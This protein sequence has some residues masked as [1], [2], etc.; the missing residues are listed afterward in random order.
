[1]ADEL[2]VRELEAEDL[3]A[4]LALYAHLH[5]GDD[6]LPERVEVERVWYAIE[7]DPAQIYMGGFVG[8]QLVAACNAAVI[9]NLTRGARPYAV[10]ENVVTDAA[11]R[12]QG[13]GARV[14][15]ALLACCW[16]RG[17][18]KVMLMSATTRGPAHGFYEALGFSKTAKQAFVISM[19]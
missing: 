13:I 9:A 5:E 15:Q 12:R 11:H 17:C 16:E 2:R 10:I 3:D 14:M 1:M 6:P 7:A 19:R 8:G 18:Y 4:L